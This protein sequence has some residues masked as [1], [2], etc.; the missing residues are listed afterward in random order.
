MLLAACGG[1]EPS[2]FVPF[3]T[4]VR[5]FRAWESKAL[6]W[7]PGL[8]DSHIAGERTVYLNRRPPH[9]ATAWPVGTLIVKVVH[10]TDQIFAMAKRGEGYN[11]DGARGWEWMELEEQLGELRIRWRGLGPPSGEGYFGDVAGSCNGCHSA[12][13][14]NDYVHPSDLRLTDY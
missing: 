4:D 9:G 6:P 1:S 2:S 14:E 8:G 3:L 7:A 10:E 12:S 11:E 13:R 5:G